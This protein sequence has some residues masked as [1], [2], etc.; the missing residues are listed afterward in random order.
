MGLRCFF[1]LIRIRIVA[2]LPLIPVD[3]TGSQVSPPHSALIHH[4]LA[5]ILP[6]HPHPHPHH[7]H[8][9]P[10]TRRHHWFPGQTSRVPSRAVVAG[11]RW[12]WH[13][14]RR[15]HHLHLRNPRCPLASRNEVRHPCN[16]CPS[17]CLGQCFQSQAP[18]APLRRPNNQ[19]G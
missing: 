1:L 18:Q 13:R 10:H 17:G 12:G 6:P 7:R 14:D 5:M 16:C 9:R 11:W 3:I 15:F 19:E 2:I 8:P 4:R